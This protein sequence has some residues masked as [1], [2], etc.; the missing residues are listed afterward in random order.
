MVALCKHSQT[1]RDV[2]CSD[3]DWWIT[4]ARQQ[5]PTN[6]PPNPHSPHKS[7]IFHVTFSHAHH[8]SLFGRQPLSGWEPIINTQSPN[9]FW[10][11]LPGVHLSLQ[12]S[13]LKAFCREVAKILLHLSFLKL[14]TLLRDPTTALQEWTSLESQRVQQTSLVNSSRQMVHKGS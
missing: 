4:W 9:L 12:D 5:S 3:L 8:L 14:N 2:D 13:S 10:L 7:K 11:L 6:P 1:L